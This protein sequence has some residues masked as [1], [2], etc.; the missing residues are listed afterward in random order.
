MSPPRRA[1]STASRPR[2]CAVIGVDD[3]PSRAVYRRA[4]QRAG[5]AASC[6]WRSSRRSPAASRAAPACWS[7]PTATWSTSPTCRPCRATTTAQ[8]AAC[9][10]AAC[11]WLGVPRETI[12]ARRCRPIPACRI[13]WSGSRAIGGVVFV[14]DSKATNADATARGA[15]AYRRHLLDRSAARPKEGGIA[16]LAP[17]FDAHP[18]CLPD[19]R[20]GRLFAGQLDGKLPFSRCGDL[21][22]ALD[23]AHAR[24]AAPRRRR[25]RVVL[26]SPAC[27]SFDQLRELRAARRCVPRAWRAPCRARRLLGRSSVIQ[28]PRDD[29]SVVGHWWWTVD[30]W[31]LGAVLAHHRRSA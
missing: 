20:G 17:W 8:N 22:S 31:S 16:S 29:R 11:R 23:A 7:T 27:A 13:A 25:R 2:D 21:Q 3:E 6:R 14:N 24:A 4:G 15:V 30:R 1:S 26:L 5:I 28:V 9:A 19:R 18:P 10:W 12:V